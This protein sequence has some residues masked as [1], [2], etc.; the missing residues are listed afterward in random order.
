MRA[1]FAS[2]AQGG[3]GGVKFAVRLLETTATGFLRANI[4]ACINTLL[5][6]GGVTF[7]VVLG[8]SAV[9]GVVAERFACGS[10]SGWGCGW[11]D[12]LHRVQSGEER[13]GLGL[14]GG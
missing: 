9:E 1:F 12:R 11:P 5:G 3:W 10:G 8:C 14:T 13:C 6:C 2:G 4:F 7:A